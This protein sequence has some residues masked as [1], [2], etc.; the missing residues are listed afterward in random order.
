MPWKT[1]T[2]EKT[3]PSLA[4]KRRLT[5]EV[6]VTP[7]PPMRRFHAETDGRYGSFVVV[8]FGSKLVGRFGHWSQRG[9]GH[10]AN[11]SWWRAGLRPFLAWNQYDTPCFWQ[12]FVRRAS[13]W[14]SAWFAP[15]LIPPS[16]SALG[17]SSLAARFPLHLLKFKFFVDKVKNKK[18]PKARRAEQSVYSQT[19]NVSGTK[20]AR[21]I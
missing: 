4:V 12:P 6:M 8:K 11:S 20:A 9:S 17:I 2:T 1:T 16:A 3:W 7:K 18:D 10:G 15:R 14:T 19:F 13:L 5:P 21:C